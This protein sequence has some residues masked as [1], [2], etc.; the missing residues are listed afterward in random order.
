MV[1]TASNNDSI[2]RLNDGEVSLIVAWD[3]DTQVNLKKGSLF[4][5]AVI[6][7]PDMGSAGG[8]DTAGVLKNATHKAAAILFLAFLTEAD[9]QIKM[10]D[11]IGSYLAR[12]DVKGKYALLPEEQRQKNGVAWIPAPY[13][14]H[15]IK[16]FIKNVLMK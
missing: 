5:R 10:N 9:S 12:T 2:S 4:K 13:K 14:D 3:D 8:G 1:I 11:T 7:V 16:E 15:F 6:Y